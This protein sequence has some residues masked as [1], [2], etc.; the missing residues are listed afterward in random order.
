MVQTYLKN[1]KKCSA[2]VKTSFT[3][4]GYLT[5]GNNRPKC[6]LSWNPS[7]GSQL[8]R[9]KLRRDFGTEERNEKDRI[10]Y[11]HQT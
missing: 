9:D 3:R 4:Q 11:A 6:H 10:A 5:H 7:I 2:G 1:A 8:L